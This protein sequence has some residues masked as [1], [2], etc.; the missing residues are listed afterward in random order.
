MLLGT[1]C[2]LCSLIKDTSGVKGSISRCTRRREDSESE[3]V[4]ERED[5]FPSISYRRVDTNFYLPHIGGCNMLPRVHQFISKPA[6]SRFACFKNKIQ[7]F[8][9]V[10]ARGGKRR[11]RPVKLFLRKSRK[12]EGGVYSCSGYERYHRR[13]Q[14]GEMDMSKMKR[15]RSKNYLPT[16]S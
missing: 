2:H 3:Q 8:G 11:G 14:E 15:Q 7:L 5:Q 12:M 10:I 6:A 13:K 1:P 9:R 16:P 4:L